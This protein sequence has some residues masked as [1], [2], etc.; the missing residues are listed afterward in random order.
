MPSLASFCN[1]KISLF[2]ELEILPL[3]CFLWFYVYRQRVNPIPFTWLFLHL[4]IASMSHWVNLLQISC[5][6]VSIITPSG[7]KSS[8]HPVLWTGSRLSMSL[9]VIPRAEHNI[10][11]WAL[12]AKIAWD[13]E[14]SALYI[15][16]YCTLSQCT[17]DYT[18][19]LGH[20]TP[21]YSPHAHLPYVF[22]CTVI[23]G[24]KAMP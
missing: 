23:S 17:G 1:Y 21:Q 12:H 5:L 22:M 14:L 3:V 15:H 16:F 2:I 8:Q 10:H 9:S 18:E 24:P 11:V 20:K 7:L 13:H 19:L 4:M 6:I